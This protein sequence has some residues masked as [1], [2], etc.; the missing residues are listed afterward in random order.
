AAPLPD[1][2]ARALA[3]RARGVHRALGQHEAVARA[4]A[5][6]LPLG[7]EGDLALDHPQ[8]LVVVVRVGGVVGVGRV[9]PGEGLEAVGRE[10]GSKRTLRRRLRAVPRNSFETHGADSPFGYPGTGSSVAAR[11]TSMQRRQ[12]KP[13]S[14]T[15]TTSSA[16]F[17]R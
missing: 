8:A 5:E 15:A 13:S 17:G 11:I 6:L 1:Q 2:V 12:K 9:G 16:D 14:D 4:E 10:A 3:P 7:A